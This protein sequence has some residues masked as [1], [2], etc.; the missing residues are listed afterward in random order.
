MVLSR[1]S[2]ED[3]RLEPVR[4]A[5]VWP[6]CAKGTTSHSRS[7][8]AASATPLA[9]AAHA[10]ARTKRESPSEALLSDGDFILCCCSVVI[11]Y[12][13]TLGSNPDVTSAAY[14]PNDT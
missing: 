14:I 1:R 7:K 9:I 12:S 4:Y 3:R 13:F 6:N 10:P 5:S 11:I 8:E 2:P